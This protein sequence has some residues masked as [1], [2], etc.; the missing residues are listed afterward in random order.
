MR[1]SH[2]CSPRGAGGVAAGGGDAD[3]FA[4]NPREIFVSRPV[5]YYRCPTTFLGAIGSVSGVSRAGYANSYAEGRDRAEGEGEDLLEHFA[6][7]A[8]R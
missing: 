6:C 8:R 3:R 5:V 4:R 7:A 2:G 1:G